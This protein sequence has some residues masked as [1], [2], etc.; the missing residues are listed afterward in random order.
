M[1]VT[2]EARR[3]A[4]TM[5]VS[6]Q[7]PEAAVEGQKDANDPTATCAVRDGNRFEAGFSPYRRTRLNR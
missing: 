2:F 5:S 3:A 4:L 6:R 1:A 7:R